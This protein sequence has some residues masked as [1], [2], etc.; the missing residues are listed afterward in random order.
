M[1]NTTV[2]LARLC[3]P[4]RGRA[5]SSAAGFVPSAHKAAAAGYTQLIGARNDAQ[6]ASKAWSPPD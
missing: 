5:V 1:S 4:V 2:V 3:M 6:G